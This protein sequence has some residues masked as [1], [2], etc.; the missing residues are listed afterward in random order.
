[1]K[2]TLLVAV[3]LAVICAAAFAQGGPPRGGPGGPGGG[4]PPMSAAMTIMPPPPG[5][6]EPLTKA[7][8]LTTQQAA[9]LK[10]VL[11]ASDA[12]LVPL[13]KT[14][15]DAAKAVHEAVFAETYD[16][17]AVAAAV[18]AS[19]NA[20]AAVVASCIDTWSKIRG[21][22]TAEQFAKIKVGPGPGGPPPPGPP[23]GGGPGSKGGSGRR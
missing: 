2:R 16:A 15:S 12:A 19:A 10:V 3:V 14:A 13:M 23:P 11:D 20:E 18:T 5:A 6:L 7:L 17:D 9:D 4:P 22:L 8:S 21:I 1:M